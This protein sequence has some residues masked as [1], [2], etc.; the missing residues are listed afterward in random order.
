M[1]RDAISLA[2]KLDEA[3]VRWDKKRRVMGLHLR[4][5][6]DEGGKLGG[7]DE[8]GH[9]P[10]EFVLLLIFKVSRNMLTG[11]VCISRDRF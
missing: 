4:G 3:G 10:M 5:I 2:G 9:G 1:M 8:G 7:R 6:W 11:G